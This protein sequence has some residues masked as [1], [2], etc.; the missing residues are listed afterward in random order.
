MYSTAL[1]VS[2][3]HACKEQKSKYRSQIQ[4][5]GWPQLHIGATAHAAKASAK[6]QCEFDAWI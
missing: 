1:R 6:H 3:M 2:L 5:D 4:Q